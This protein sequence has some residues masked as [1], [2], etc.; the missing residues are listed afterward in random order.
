MRTTNRG[1]TFLLLSLTVVLTAVLALGAGACSSGRHVIVDRVQP[2]TI[3]TGANDVVLRVDTRGGFTP[4]EYQLGIVPGLTVYGDGRVIESGPVTEQYP[5]HALPNLVTGRLSRDAIGR[6][7]QLA[8]DAE[9]LG[10]AIDFGRPGVTDMA[11]TE[12]TI[13]ASTCSDR[14][15]CPAP[16]PQ[17]A[18][19]LEFPPVH[20]DPGL[21]TAQLAA[22]RRLR[23][24]VAAVDRA[25]T[26]AAT[27][28][29][30]ASEVAVYARPADTVAAGVDGIEPGAAD[31]PLGDL[32]TIG[33]PIGGTGAN[34]TYRCAVVRGS[35]AERVLAAAAG[36][37]SITRW[38]AAG[39]EYSIVFRPLLPNEHTCP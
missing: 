25:A 34:T 35:D 14:A 13:N 10:P 16:T 37:S 18:Y 2:P 7:V 32:A 28:P 21:S 29:Y 26:R 3:P 15:A 38:R 1:S 12:V 31:W 20:G 5:P 8:A 39:A 6:L 11:T 17:H 19:A 33:T 36:A 4:V 9:L 22:R 24:W 23:S 27:E 30:V